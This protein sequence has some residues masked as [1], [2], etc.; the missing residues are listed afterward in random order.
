MKT[1]LNTPQIGANALP[2]KAKI[3]CVIALFF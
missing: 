2:V 3:V 1:F